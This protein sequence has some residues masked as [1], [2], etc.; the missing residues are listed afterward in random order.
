ML[1]WLIVELILAA[2]DAAT[3]PNLHIIESYIAVQEEQAC[4]FAAQFQAKDA[5]EEV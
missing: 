3:Q 4:I 1:Q 5:G 2:S